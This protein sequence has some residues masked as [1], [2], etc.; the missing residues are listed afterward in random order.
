MRQLNHF[1]RAGETTPALVV[2]IFLVYNK[3]ECVKYRLLP[4][5]L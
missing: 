4:F 5:E 2:C 3:I 1:A